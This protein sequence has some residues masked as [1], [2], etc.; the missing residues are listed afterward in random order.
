MDASNMTGRAI[1]DQ[2][3]ARMEL[4]ADRI[5]SKTKLFEALEA[6]GMSRDSVTKFYYGT[7]PNPGIN[8]LD[9]LVSALDQ[10]ER[11]LPEAA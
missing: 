5:G 11:D 10:V 2:A 8:L 4:I 6:A 9:R 7:R 1:A 3:R